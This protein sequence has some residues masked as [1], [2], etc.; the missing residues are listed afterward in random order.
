[1]RQGA[2]LADVLL[3]EPYGIAIDCGRSI[4]SPARIVALNLVAGEAI[5]ST[6]SGSGN[7]NIAD[8]RDGVETGKSDAWIVLRPGR[9]E[10][11]HASTALSDCHGAVGYVEVG[12]G[13][14]TLIDDCGT[15]SSTARLWMENEVGKAGTAIGGSVIGDAGS[16]GSP[17]FAVGVEDLPDA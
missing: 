1:L 4:V 5:L 14:V 9:C 8:A 10:G 6:Y 12:N 13:E 16:E 2:G 17:E 7:L 3:S 15:R 11:E